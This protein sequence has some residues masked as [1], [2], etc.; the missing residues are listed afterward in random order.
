MT[1]SGDTPIVSLADT[2]V[3]GDVVSGRPGKTPL[4]DEPT[5]T[6]GEPPP[7]ID[8]LV[9]EPVTET[10]VT[11][12]AWRPP[13]WSCFLALFVILIAITFG[14]IG[15][16]TAHE[17]GLVSVT[18]VTPDDS[19]PYT[20]QKPDRRTTGGGA[21]SFT[22]NVQMTVHYT[23]FNQ[24]SNL[25][26]PAQLNL[27]SGRF[28]LDPQGIPPFD[29]TLGAGNAV[30]APG[31]EG[32]VSGTLADGATQNLTLTT[33]NFPCKGV[34]PMTLQLPTPLSA[35]PAVVL[36]PP[37]A[38]SIDSP[39]L[40]DPTGL[41]GNVG[42]GERDVLWP[43]IIGGSLLDVVGLLILFYFGWREYREYRWM[44][45]ELD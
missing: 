39:V 20:P 17:G 2:I 26:L 35:T 16:R 29:G 4:V 1:Q 44:L 25:T 19:I 38:D 33:T 34:F 10:Y 8:V 7:L 6:T 5:P 37:L 18:S 40:I 21:L 11:P 24:T 32:T 12:R 14:V 3:A 9:D 43:V 27:G 23:C 13:C 36:G 15:Y 30:N 42:G 41:S 45:E 31:Q 28:F 22:G